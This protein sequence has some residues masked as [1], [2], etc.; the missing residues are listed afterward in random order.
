MLPVTTQYSLHT[1]AM[2]G[3]R[4]LCIRCK[5]CERRVNLDLGEMVFQGNMKP[6]Y[7]LNLKCSELRG[8]C[9]SKDLE[10]SIPLDLKEAMAFVQIKKAAP[11]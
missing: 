5:N 8:G 1:I 2:Y 3:H 4:M 11:G 6:L 10:L 9:G 7:T